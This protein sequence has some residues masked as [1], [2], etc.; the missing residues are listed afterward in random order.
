MREFTAAPLLSQHRSPAGA[1][2]GASR[3][4]RQ[5]IPAHSASSGPSPGDYSTY[6]TSTTRQ[7]NSRFESSPAFSMGSAVRDKVGDA[8]P[9]SR[10]DQAHRSRLS[11]QGTKFAQAGNTRSHPEELS[12]GPGLYSPESVSS[13]GRPRLAGLAPSPPSFGFGKPGTRFGGTN[14]RDTQNG[15]R[16]PDSAALGAAVAATKPSSAAFSFGPP[17]SLRSRGGTTSQHKAVTAQP[18][19]SPIVSTAPDGFGRQAVSHHRSACGFSFGKGIREGSLSARTAGADDTPGPGDYQ[20]S[21]PGTMAASQRTFA[22]SVSPFR[23]APAPSFGA[24]RPHTARTGT[25]LTPA[26]RAQREVDMQAK[27]QAAAVRRDAWIAAA[28]GGAAQASGGFGSS[29]RGEQG[30]PHATTQV[31]RD[32]TSYSD[33]RPITLAPSSAERIL[34]RARGIQ[35][36]ELAQRWGWCG[37]PVCDKHQQRANY[38]AQGGVQRGPLSEESAGSAAFSWTWSICASGGKGGQ[39]GQD[40]TPAHHSAPQRSSCE[41]TVPWT[42]CLLSRHLER[43]WGHQGRGPFVFSGG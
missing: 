18:A 22:S 27:L 41:R 33:A 16:I 30:A 25:V 26:E 15:G 14:T 31:S 34:P 7:V 36:T 3:S 21:M 20:S 13:L 29:R 17:P 8:A 39:G 4:S 42:R 43:H 35:P 6:I 10:S 24:V 12:P 28:G 2:F 23:R 38:G 9:L 1:A 19:V 32:C 40:C 37:K 11:L 5:G